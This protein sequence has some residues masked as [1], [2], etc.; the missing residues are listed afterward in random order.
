MTAAYF[1]TLSKSLLINHI[2]AFKEMLCQ[3]LTAFIHK[4][5]NKYDIKKVCPWELLQASRISWSFNSQNR[6][7]ITLTVQ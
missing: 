2:P 5:Q 1:H 6:S 3:L 4:L 7:Y